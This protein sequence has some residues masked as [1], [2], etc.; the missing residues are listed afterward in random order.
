M[1]ATPAHVY[2]GQLQ[3]SGLRFAIVCA[4]FNDFFV[5]HL[6][7]GAMDTLL[8]HGAKAAD[9][10]VAWVPGSFEIPL[11]ARRLAASGKYDAVLTL[12]VVIQGATPHAGFINSTIAGSFASIMADTGVPVIYGVLTTETLEQA[13]ERSGTKHGNRGSSVAETAIEMAS[14]MR[15][16][17]ADHPAK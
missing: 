12:G 1:H 2:E 3:A 13:M 10:T 16:L 9:L 11:I 7:D 15:G 5:S 6:L 14:L 4:R 17:A 8:R